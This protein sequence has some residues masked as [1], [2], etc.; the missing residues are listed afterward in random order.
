[1]RLREFFLTETAEEDR[2]IIS[3]AL[4][5]Y[6]YLQQYADQDLDYD[7]EDEIIY[8]GKI[9][10]LFDTPL[11]G[12][13]HVRLEIQSDIG[14]LERIND[15]RALSGEKPIFEA[16][17]G[18]WYSDTNT[19]V[20]NADYLSVDSM[21][22]AISHELRHA[23]DDVKSDYR[24]SDSAFYSTPRKKSH[25]K[26]TK[27]PKLG[28]LTYLAQPAEINARFVQVLDDMV[29]NIARMKSLPLEKARRNLH[30]ILIY[31][32]EKNEIAQ[33]FPEKE[34]SKHYKRLLKRGAEF[35][36]KE[37]AYHHSELEKNKKQA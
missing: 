9:G 10:Q 21:K 12:L 3:L 34:K 19:I 36:D 24:V 8:V 4:P 14:L 32:M 33:L 37:L 17:G 31:R 25:R 6:K 15:R 1:M 18:V 26:V 20:L 22:S 11:E 30:K 16:P 5:I 23:L 29:P 28:D 27:D 35:I 2:A 7:D 13:R